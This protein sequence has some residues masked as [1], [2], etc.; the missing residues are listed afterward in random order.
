MLAQILLHHF[1]HIYLVIQYLGLALSNHVDYFTKLTTS[2][3]NSSL[4]N[5][6]GK[7]S[8]QTVDNHDQRELDSISRL[9]K[10][11][12]KIILAESI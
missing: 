8:T 9:Q 4:T 7:Q 10:L 5:T 1:L 3:L 2:H 6:M 11:K 12:W